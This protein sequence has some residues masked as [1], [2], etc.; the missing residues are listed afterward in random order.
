MY[1]VK[2]IH[3][4]NGEKDIRV[5]KRPVYEKGDFKIKFDLK[6]DVK[7]IEKMRRSDFGY[8]WEYD[9]SQ[10]CFI[11]KPNFHQSNLFKP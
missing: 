8:F 1:N 5:F 2:V 7:R 9:P 10:M 3:Y 4:L 11:E 6:K